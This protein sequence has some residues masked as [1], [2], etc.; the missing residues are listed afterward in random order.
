MID[1]FARLLVTIA[2]A[3]LAPACATDTMVESASQKP[4]RIEYGR[5]E[6]IQIYRGTDSQPINA[7]TLLG[8]V[9]GGV[10][11]HQIGSGR[12]NTAATI[13]GAVA[14]GVIGHEVEKARSEQDRYRITVRLDSGATLSVDDANDLN[15]R[16]GDRVRIENNRIY[17]L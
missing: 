8:G 6:A 4:T 16:T 15:L 13:V 3:L 2:C 17:R 12:G 7:G 14:G 11:G 10:I 1:R 5:V 9:A